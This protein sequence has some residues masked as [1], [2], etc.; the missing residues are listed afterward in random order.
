MPPVRFDIEHAED[1]E[2]AEEAAQNAGKLN[3]SLPPWD[4][5]PDETGPSRFARIED[6]P[7][8][9]DI[10]AADIE[11][12]VEDL[13]AR[14]TVCLLT[15][16]SGCGKSTFACALA[17]AVSK[18]RDFLGRATTKRPVLILDAEN[19]SIAVIERF[20]RLGIATDD[21]FRVWGQWTGEDPPAAG[22]ALVLE[23]ITRCEP[24]PLIVVDSLIRFHPGAENSSTETQEYMNMYRK[25]AAAGASVLPLHHIGK[26]ESA[27]DYRGSSDIKASVD[28]AFKLTSL[29]DGSRLSLLELRAFKQRISVTPHLFIR[30]EDGQFTT[31]EREATKT[32]TE[33]L[34]DLLKANPGITSE[35]FERLA[36]SQ[37]LGRNRARTFLQTGIGSGTVRTEHGACNRREHFWSE[38]GDENSWVS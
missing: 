1:I 35:R 17:Y 24:K 9:E 14:A 18:G 2:A 16:E 32:V 38:N 15:G 31:D 26:A 23:W 3:G 19:P 13:I 28:V 5:Q 20:Q 12:D 27:Q 10:A 21:N 22:G 30:Y 33:R 4:E 36:A 11:W 29:G 7:R 6:L 34:V 25:L 8:V 37:H